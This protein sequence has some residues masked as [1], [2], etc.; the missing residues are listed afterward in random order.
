MLKMVHCGHHRYIYLLIFNFTACLII[1][2]TFCSYEVH[3]IAF[4]CSLEI[5]QVFV[6]LVQVASHSV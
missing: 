5:C 2:Q 4:K 6:T 3:L 1:V